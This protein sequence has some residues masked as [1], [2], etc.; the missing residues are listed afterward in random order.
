MKLHV[1]LRDGFNDDNVSI[2][3]N[4]R[5]VYHKSGVSTDL[6][7]SFADS[8]EIPVETAVVTLKVAVEGGETEEKEIRVK[9]TPFVDV[10]LTGQKMELRESREEV[11]ML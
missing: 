4:G 11:P 1:K 2:R 6:S 5:E 3:V 7:V 10:W 9:Q 8:V